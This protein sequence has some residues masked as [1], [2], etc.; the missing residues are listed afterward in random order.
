MYDT[1]LWDNDGVLVDTEGLFFAETKAAFAELGLE[2]TVEIWAATY[3]GKG[4]PSREIA[5]EMGADPERIGPVLSERDRR[6]M[7]ALEQPIVVRPKVRETLAALAG[8][9]RMAMVTGCDR[10]QLKLKHDT[11]ELLDYFEVIV[12]ADECERPKPD[13]EAYLIAMDELGV[14][15]SSCLAVED[16]QR[17]LAAALS[18]GIACVVV[19]TELTC[20]QDFGGALSV[21]EDVSGVMKYLQV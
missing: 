4:T 20:G 10:D 3:L 17:G 9:V 13:P 11:G 6:H 14:E 21:E 16:S 2:L 7:L 5:R 1:I 12:T 18:A 15:K 19:P 8:K